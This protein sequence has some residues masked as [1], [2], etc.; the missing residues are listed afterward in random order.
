VDIIIC[1]WLNHLVKSTLYKLY[2]IKTEMS[3][4]DQNEP[5]AS[6]STANNEEAFGEQIDIE[7]VDI[8]RAPE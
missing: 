3:A 4:L 6:T 1:Q 5:V 7:Q 8:E 2:D